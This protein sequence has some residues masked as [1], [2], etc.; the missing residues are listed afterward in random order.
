MSRELGTSSEEFRKKTLATAKEYK[1]E[2]EVLETI[3]HIHETITV[4]REKE[5][6]EQKK[7]R[8]EELEKLKN[9]AKNT[10]NQ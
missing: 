2:E 4:P 8:E 6:E 7:R 3:S 10:Q 9:A 1:V 5:R